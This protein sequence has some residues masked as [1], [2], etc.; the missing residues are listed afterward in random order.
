MATSTQ[1]QLP[2]H[3]ATGQGQVQPQQPA[4]QLPPHVASGQG[5]VNPLAAM[6]QDEGTMTRLKDG[7][8]NVM[9]TLAEDEPLRQFLIDFGTTAMQPREAGVGQGA[10]L[11]RAVQAGMQGMQS[12]QE[13]ARQAALA[14]RQEERADA[15][16]EQAGERIDIQREGVRQRGEI[17]AADREQRGELAAADRQQRERESA[18]RFSILSDKQDWTQ[19]YQ[20]ER[21]DL[22]AQELDVKRDQLALDTTQNDPAA[23]QTVKAFGQ[24]L[25]T[26]NPDKYQGE[27]GDAQAMLDAHATINSSRQEP[28]ELTATKIAFDLNQP[29]PGVQVDMEAVESTRKE[30]LK[31]LQQAEPAGGGSGNTQTPKAGDLPGRSERE[32]FKAEIQ[33]SGRQGNFGLGA[34]D[35]DEGGYEIIDNDTG[36][37]RGYW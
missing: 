7:W 26:T 31:M 34:Y 10:M 30:A 24:W 5:Q 23:L 28:P 6:P 1:Q 13:R 32:Q 14:Q 33:Q 29:L 4:Q 18:R 20:S 21:L 25:K 12:A 19:E 16:V 9:Q 35:P 15:Q 3:V 2:P 11:G 27:D 36:Q 22:M 37:V 17:A 8:K